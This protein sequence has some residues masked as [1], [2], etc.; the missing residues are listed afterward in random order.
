MIDLKARIGREWIEINELTWMN[1]KEWIEMNE[2]KGMNCK[3]WIAK[4]API[5]AAFDGGYVKSSS[6]Y[7]LVP[8]NM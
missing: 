4:S 8:Y 1:W 7:S 2:L 5:P 6:R 3:E